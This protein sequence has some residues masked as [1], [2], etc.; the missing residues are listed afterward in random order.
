M[1]GERSQEAPSKPAI[2]VVCVKSQQLE[3]TLPLIGNHLTPELC[4]DWKSSSQLPESHQR[5]LK[6]MTLEGKEKAVIIFLERLLICHYRFEPFCSTSA[7]SLS[8]SLEAAWSSLRALGMAVAN[9]AKGPLVLSWIS[10][11]EGENNPPYLPR[12]SVFPRAGISSVSC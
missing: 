5:D 9:W 7:S 8:L 4:S 10:W 1:A 3:V 2:N 11:G 6:R 12:H